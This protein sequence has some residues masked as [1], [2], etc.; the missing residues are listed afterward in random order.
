M[1]DLNRS[2]VLDILREQSPI[3]RAAIANVAGLTKPTVSAIVDDLIAEDL[4]AE[5]GIGTTTTA[6]GRPPMM[7][8]FNERSQFVVGVHIGVRRTTIVVADAKGQELG[9][10]VDSTPKG[11]ST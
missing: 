1:R 3:S 7:L 9:R 5:I 2:L 11:K 8:R 4:A 6:G 10:V